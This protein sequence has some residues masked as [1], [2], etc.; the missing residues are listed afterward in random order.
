VFGGDAVTAVNVGTYPITASGLTSDLG[1]TVNDFSGQLTIT[2]QDVT[3]QAV[4]V[5]NKTYD[6]TTQA[7]IASSTLTGTVGSETLNVTGTAHFI[8]ANVGKS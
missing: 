3:L 8:D 5:D 1:Y 6:G 7:T 2:P 4:T